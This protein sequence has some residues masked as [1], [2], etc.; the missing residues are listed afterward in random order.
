M[1]Q[2]RSDVVGATCGRPRTP[3][4]NDRKRP[5]N[6]PASPVGA[7]CG[8]P[9]TPHRNDRKRPANRLTFPVGADDLGRPRIPHRNDRKRPVNRLA[10]P[11]GATCGR[12]RT[13]HRNDWKRPANWPAS[14]VGATCGRPPT[15]AVIPH[16]GDRRSP[17]QTLLQSIP[18][19]TRHSSAKT[20]LFLYRSQSQYLKTKSKPGKV[21]LIWRGRPG[22]WLRS[23]RACLGCGAKRARSDEMK[24]KRKT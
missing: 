9:R 7:T 22:K 14:P 6:W 23:R 16:A 15:P 18:T 20:F 2:A 4:R 17:L 12:P 3:H 11:V 8:R 5:A 21:G 13:P 1:E 19:S 10:S 24:G